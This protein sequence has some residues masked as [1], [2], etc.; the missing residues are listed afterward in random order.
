MKRNYDGEDGDK[1]GGHTARSSMLHC[2]DEGTGVDNDT[3]VD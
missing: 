3:C 2:D 1:D